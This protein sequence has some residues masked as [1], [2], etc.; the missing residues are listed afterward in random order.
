M[1]NGENNSG[2]NK[3]GMSSGN[4]HHG[5]NYNNHQHHHGN[6]GS[7]WAN[8]FNRGNKYDD[9]HHPSPSRSN[10]GG[11]PSDYDLKAV[12]QGVHGLSV[13]NNGQQK[14]GDSSGGG[15]SSKKMTWAT[16]ASQPAK[17]QVT[18]TSLLVKKKGKGMP[19]PPMVP[20]KHNLDIGAWDSP[21][22]EATPPPYPP[23]PPPVE[24]SPIPLNAQHQQA[25]EREEQQLRQQQQH[26]QNNYGGGGN[27]DHHHYNSNRD[28]AGG[29]HNNN[30]NGYNREK[31]PWQQGQPHVGNHPQQTP[32][33]VNNRPMQEPHNANYNNNNHHGGGGFGFRNN[34]PGT[35]YQQHHH[36]QQIHRQQSQS[37]TGGAEPEDSRP[38]Q[39]PQASERPERVGGGGGHSG[40]ARNAKLSEGDTE[41]SEEL[42]REMLDKLMD[43]RNYNPPA[44]ELERGKNARFFVIKSY[45]EDD[46]HRSIKYEIWCSTEHGNKRLDQAYR[47]RESKDGN[48]LL[49]FS[50]NGSGHFC[51]IAQMISAVDYNSK[52]TV[53]A[54]DKWKGVFK[55]KWIYVKDVPN[56]LL[57]QIRLENNEDKPVTNS[58]DTQEVPNPQ[59]LKMLEIIHGFK[60][61][62][63]IFD[64]FSH[65]EQRQ[66]E[67]DSRKHVDPPIMGQRYGGGERDYQGGYHNN[68]HGGGYNQHQQRPQ[69]NNRGYSGGDNYRRPAFGHRDNNYEGGGGGGNGNYNRE[70][71]Y[72][73]G[74]GGAFNNRGGDREHN[75]YDNNYQQQRSF[76]STNDRDGNYRRDYRVSLSGESCKVLLNVIL[77]YRTT[78]TTVAG[79]EAT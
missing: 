59:G 34:G 50:V 58:R 55:V 73:S 54:Q 5:G 9:Y 29:Y 70:G 26:H 64:D 25:I 15:S 71:N 62:T 12:E 49:F 69:Y 27:R 28:F 66:E 52:S 76:G 48:L 78:I 14:R 46:I 36:Q 8:Q 68:D 24:P 63:S 23:T 74:P 7:S 44:L 19:P 1:Q 56:T 79:A 32:Q 11:P 45:S 38:P 10:R 4:Q 75:N 3:Y 33:N 6:N 16:V 39:Q 30:S 18:T 17:P 47:E 67:E 65:Y 31:R 37:P 72:R 22:K 35:G 61:T 42:T 41:E 77:P 57:R 43:K 53:W 20:G 13:N 40:P 21:V 2:S 51:G 60:H